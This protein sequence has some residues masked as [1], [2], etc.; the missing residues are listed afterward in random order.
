MGTLFSRIRIAVGA[1]VLVAALVV[2]PVAVCGTYY[3]RPDGGTASQCNGKVN[4]PASAAP[5]CSWAAPTIALPVGNDSYGGVIPKARIKAGD[6]LVI[7]SG[8]YMVG[9]GAPGYERTGSCYPGGAYNCSIANIPSGIDAARPTVI[10]GDCSAPPQLWGTQRTT[11][12]QIYKAH[13]IKI[14]CLDITD[15]SPCIYNYGPTTATGGVTPC[16][17]GNYPYGTY[18]MTGIRAVDVTNLTLDHVVVHGLAQ[19]GIVAG[20]LHGNT[21]ISN[22]TIRANGWGGW[23]G[24]LAG[25]GYAGGSGNDGRLLFDNLKVEWNGC[26]EAYPASTIVGCWGQSNGGYGDGLGTAATGGDWTFNNATFLQNTSDGLD[27]LYHTLGG[28]VAVNGGVFWGNI[29]NQIKLAGDATITRAVVNGM[30]DDFAQF[31]VGGAVGNSSN[32]CRAAGTAIVMVQDAPNQKSQIIYSTITGNGDT[33]L[34]GGG[35][36]SNNYEPVASNVWLYQNN[37]FLGQPSV[38][39]EGEQTA[40]DWYSDGGFAGTVQYINNIVWNVKNGKC[41]GDS[42]CKAPRLQNQTLAH[43]NPAL[44]E[45]SPAKDGARAVGDHRPPFPNIGAVQPS[46][47]E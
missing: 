8:R 27:L 40:L 12:I 34:V 30:C 43:F 22:V 28:T 9:I 1:V 47:G 6:T 13:D 20:Q 19:Y 2:S 31:P 46:N 5:D 15:H 45:G 32:N 23:N 38:Y 33:L 37:I 36:E 11:V 35:S 17:Y 26:A 39:R 18:A 29:G 16:N 4:A 25:L 44:L 42:I 24:D 3:V 10:T 21:T 41:P 7:A 14:A